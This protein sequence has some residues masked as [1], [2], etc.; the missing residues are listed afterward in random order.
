MNK[1]KAKWWETFSITNNF[2]LVLERVGLHNPFRSA[3]TLY[4]MNLYRRLEGEEV[5]DG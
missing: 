5:D 1:K 2:F 3:D 4:R